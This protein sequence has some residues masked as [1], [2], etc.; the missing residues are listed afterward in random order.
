MDPYMFFRTA[1]YEGRVSYYEYGPLLEE[2]PQLE[3]NKVRKR[4]D[5]PPRGKKDLGDGA[6]GV[7]YHVHTLAMS[8]PVMPARGLSEEA[9]PS[10]EDPRARCRQPGCVRIGEVFGWCRTHWEEKSPEERGRLAE[11]RR[12]DIIW[13]LAVPEE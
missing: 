8:E 13:S 10:A 3:H 12:E 9:P 6:A 1:L 7:A 5:H 4:I 2:L 11:E